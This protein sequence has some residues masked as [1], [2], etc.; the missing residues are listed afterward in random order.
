M[1]S[2]YRLILTTLVLSLRL[3]SRRD[4]TCRDLFEDNAERDWADQPSLPRRRPI[5]NTRAPTSDFRLRYE[6]IG[7]TDG[8]YT[9]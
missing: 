6:G 2:K 3:Q 1:H 5:F 7:T 4:G 8:Y 9:R